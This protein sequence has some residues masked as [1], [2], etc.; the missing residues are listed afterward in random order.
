MKMTAVLVALLLAAAVYLLTWSAGANRESARQPQPELASVEGQV[1]WT[2]DSC[3][4]DEDWIDVLTFQRRRCAWLYPSTLDSRGQRAALPVVIL[5]QQGFRRPSER[6]TVYVTGGPGGS[7]WL[8]EEGVLGWAEWSQRMGLDHDLVLYDQRGTGLSRPALDCPALEA[9]GWSQ[10]DSDADLDSLWAEY[11]AVIKACA[12]QVPAA[13]RANGLYSTANNARDLNELVASLKRELGYR[14][15]NVYGVSYG[16]RLAMIALADSH[17]EVDAAV[18]DSLYP[19]GLDLVGPFADH[20]AAVIEAASRHC[21]A[22]RD[23]AADMQLR[24]VLDRALDRLRGQPIRYR[25]AADWLEAPVT[26]RVDDTVL[27][28]LVEHALYAGWDLSDLERLLRQAAGGRLADW[29]ELIDEWL[30]VS[31]DPDFDMLTLHLVE[32]RDNLPTDPAIEAAALARQ[33]SW[34]STLASPKRSYMLCDEL[35]VRPAPLEAVELR[36]PVLALAADFDPRTPASPGL[37]AVEQYPKL[38]VLRRPLTGH[39]LVDIDEC[40][41]TAAGRFL[42]RGGAYR[43][44][45]CAE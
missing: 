21:I 7:S 27:I 30:W 15:V 16:T 37:Q 35:G 28:T 23:C 4:F 45:Q 32:C 3:W 31:M 29:R 25:L 44:A 6:A 14:S 9:L 17:S 41:A 36:V 43:I 22:R 19:P 5:H 20:F 34:R 39:G 26:L 12:Q 40:A 38:Q 1:D 18:L 42:N 2:D 33:P 24:A 8:S 11:E 13:D 10:L